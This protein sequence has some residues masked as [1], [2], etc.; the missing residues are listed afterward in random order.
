MSEEADKLYEESVQ[1]FLKLIDSN[2]I[3]SE[4]YEFRRQEVLA[5]SHAERQS[6]LAHAK[7]ELAR[8]LKL[9]VETQMELKIIEA[10]LEER[11]RDSGK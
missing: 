10:E 7:S 4:E 5:M 11:L 2:E 9:G 3:S 6:A 8:L 1:D